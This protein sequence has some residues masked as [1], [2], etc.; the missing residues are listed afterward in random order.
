MSSLKNTS[1]KKAVNDLSQVLNSSLGGN[2]DCMRAIADIEAMISSLE[3]KL[4]NLS[5]S[6]SETNTVIATGNLNFVPESVSGKV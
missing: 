5:S 3:E 6:A 4:N 2:Q 1:L